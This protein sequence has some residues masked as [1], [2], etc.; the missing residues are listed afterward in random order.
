M[1]RPERTPHTCTAQLR[2]GGTVPRVAEIALDG[3]IHA[4]PC[5]QTGQLGRVVLVLC[6]LAP[7]I[8]MLQPAQPR[9]R[10]YSGA[11]RR[12]WFNRPSIGSVL[13]Q[14]IVNPILFMIVDVTTD[15]AAQMPLIQRD[16]VIEHLAAATSDPSFRGSV[17]PGAPARPFV[18]ASARSPSGK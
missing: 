18:W 7:H 3:L 13:V 17:L 10:N 14:G 11:G 8:P 1:A 4:A 2:N 12:L 9:Q 5:Q 15:Q 6:R 16:D